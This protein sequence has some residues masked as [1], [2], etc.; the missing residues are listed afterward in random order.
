MKW[1]F[2]D[3]DFDAIDLERHANGVIARVLERGRLE[4]V[5]WLIE[6]YGLGRIHCFLRDV[7]SSELTART[8]CFWRL[9]L[10]AKEEPW[11]EPPAWRRNSSPLWIESGS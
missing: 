10:D 6:S 1:I 3:V 5:R 11:A 8:L 2:W 7:G 4:D 9:V